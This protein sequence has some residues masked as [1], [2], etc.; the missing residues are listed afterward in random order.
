M[1]RFPSVNKR[2]LTDSFSMEER[3]LIFHNT[4]LDYVLK[5]PETTG[6]NNVVVFDE[7]SLSKWGSK[8]NPA[9]ALGVSSNRLLKPGL[10]IV[11]SMKG[12]PWLAGSCEKLT[13][14]EEG[15]LG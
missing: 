9:S 14:E 8:K 3:D 7:V 6:G 1:R 2:K 10:S 15:M 12:L 13:G 5:V 4:A 11:D